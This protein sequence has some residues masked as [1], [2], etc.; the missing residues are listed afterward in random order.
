[1]RALS[2]SLRISNSYI[3][4]VYEKDKV[5]NII[6]SEEREHWEFEGSRPGPLP[7]WRGLGS[8]WL[9]CS[10]F[11]SPPVPS[12]QRGGAVDP[13][14]GEVVQIQAVVLCRACGAWDEHLKIVSY[15]IRKCISPQGV[16]M[17]GVSSLQAVWPYMMGG[18]VVSRA[19]EK[20]SYS[21]CH[22]FTKSLRHLHHLLLC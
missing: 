14:V 3:F 18:C 17:K 19:G 22:S 5:L 10:L 16:Q 9:H 6:H 8:S 4:M 1:M 2:A 15:C 21:S 20:S 7:V 11:P 13:S 12:L